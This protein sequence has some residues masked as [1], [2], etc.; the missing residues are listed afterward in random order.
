MQQVRHHFQL[1]GGVL[2]FVTGLL[3]GILNPITEGVSNVAG[4]PLGVGHVLTGV[5]GL[6]G[7]IV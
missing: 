1:L 5:T 3:G 2:N 7:G 6:V 4:D